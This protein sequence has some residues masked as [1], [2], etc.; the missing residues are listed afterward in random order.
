MAEPIGFLMSH[1]HLGYARVTA[2][3]KATIQIQLVETKEDLSFSH[4]ALRDGTLKRAAL[5]P[6]ALCDSPRGRCTVIKLVSNGAPTYFTYEVILS[7]GGQF[8]V[9]EIDLVPV[10]RADSET[11][12]SYLRSLDPQSYVLF[13]AREDLLRAHARTMRESGGLRALLACRVDLRPHQAFVAG[14]V[15]RDRCRR[16][17]LADEVGLGKTIEAGIVITDLLAQKPNAR[18]LIVCPGSLTLQWLSELYSKFGGHV[19]RV[20]GLGAEDSRQPAVH[21]KA[22]LSMTRILQGSKDSSVTLEGSWDLVVVDE[23]H[24][25]LSSDVLYDGIQALARRVPSLLLLSAIPARRREDEYLRL[26]ALLEP[27]HYGQ[28]SARNR[29]S[30]LFD[31][32]LDIGRRLRILSRRAASLKANEIDAD[33]VV[34]AGRRLL[35]LPI[36][37]DD[38]ELRSMFESWDTT[39]S[40]FSDVTLRLVHYVADH[41]RINRRILRNRRERLIEAQ[42]I[43]R[44]ERTIKLHSYD[45]DSIEREAIDATYVLLRT[46]RASGLEQSNVAALA[47]IFLQGLVSPE[48]MLRLLDQFASATPAATA[49]SCHTLVANSHLVGGAEWSGIRDLTFVA[50]RSAV[51]ETILSVS[52]KAVERWARS[53]SRLRMEHLVNVLSTRRVEGATPKVLVFAGQSDLVTEVVTALRKAFGAKAVAEFRDDLDIEAKEKNVLQFRTKRETWL[54][55]CD[56]SGGEGRNFQFADEIVHVDTPLHVDRIE[57]RIGRLDR[58]GRE[59]QGTVASHVLVPSVTVEEAWVRCVD[60][61]LGVYK[62]SLSG[63][64]FALREVDDLLVGAAL[65]D[66]P[67]LALEALS[68]SLA[69]LAQNER[70]RDESEAVL[71]EASFQQGAVQRFRRVGGSAGAD[72]SLAEAFF[73]YF[74]VLAPG[75]AKRADDPTFPDAFFWFDAQK[76]LHGGLELPPGAPTDGR[77]LGTFRRDVAQL[78]PSKQ[79]FQ[80]GNLLFDV[81]MASLKSRST[82]R[83]YAIRCLAPSFPTPWRGFEFA[84]SAEPAVEHLIDLP[85]LVARGTQTFFGR[86]VHVMVREDGVVVDDPDKL[87]ELRRSFKSQTKDRDW[88]NLTKDKAAILERVFREQTWSNA[89]ESLYGIAMR[90]AR[91]YLLERLSQD[92]K[93]EDALVSEYEQQT[94]QILSVERDAELDAW[95]RYRKALQEWRVVLDSAG[96]L[97]VNTGMGG[98]P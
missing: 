64:E 32:Q 55:V 37:A 85:A 65:E 80:S 2:V 54:L 23:A 11:P 61:G 38:R 8:D 3:T 47:R 33:K 96:F 34:E 56:E 31:A 18:V 69:D 20:V 40:D 28:A 84:F 73:S 74:S 79:F 24:H 60:V 78:I 63:L 41:Y 83:T 88:E 29:F 62:R 27:D 5:V 25:V 46:A 15:L 67:I 53:K 36:L 42:Q 52:R 1:R 50:A 89:V 4:D 66:D 14:V 49:D 92:L 94:A 43:P 19:F 7:P 30:E 16:Y 76:V 77:F 59:C 95:R 75:G 71:D 72:A 44:I 45:P 21:S 68:S 9:S 70:A 93:F 91:G 17:I 51:P 6:G 58:L 81:V 98:V 26:L 86:S 13:R 22:I 87:L 90:A 82:G 57:Q 10:K 97:A 39:A 35:D 48:A 12:L